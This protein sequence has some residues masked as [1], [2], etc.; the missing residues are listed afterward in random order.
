MGHTHGLPGEELGVFQA[1]GL[2]EVDVEAAEEHTAEVL[3]PLQAL[4]RGGTPRRR[5]HE[6]RPVS[7]GW[8]PQSAGLAANES[9][10]HTGSA[11]LDGWR[12]A[13]RRDG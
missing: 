11:W 13:A 8:E 10:G 5:D 6:P 3:H 9:S 2:L 12:H 1:P 7:P 4:H